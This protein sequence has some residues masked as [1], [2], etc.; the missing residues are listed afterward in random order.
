M[1]DFL[2]IDF[3]FHVVERFMISATLTRTRSNLQAAGIPE[4]AL[5]TLCGYKPSTLSAAFREIAQLKSTDEAVLLTAS[6][7]LSELSDAFYPLA[8]PKS[9]GVLKHL[10]T[11]LESGELTLDQVRGSVTAIFGDLGNAA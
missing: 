5:A 4:S 6:C 11:R 2:D 1:R 10:L 8:L 9:V 7:R 3:M